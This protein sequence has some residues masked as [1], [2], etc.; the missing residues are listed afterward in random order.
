MSALQGFCVSCRENHWFSSDGPGWRCQ[1]CHHY[2]EHT[3]Q[4]NICK[5]CGHWSANQGH[6]EACMELGSPE[7]IGHDLGGALLNALDREFRAG[8]V[9]PMEDVREYIDRGYAQPL[10][11][12]DDELYR[13]TCTDAFRNELESTLGELPYFISPWISKATA[14]Y[15]AVVKA[16]SPIERSF[17]DAHQRLN[18]PELHGIFPQ[19]HALQYKIDFGRADWKIGIELDGFATHSSTTAIANDRQ[20]QRALEAEGWRIIR[21]GGQEIHRDADACVR[22]AAELVRKLLPWTD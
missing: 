16:M 7:R 1:K 22:Q 11:A 15:Q 17:W 13:L 21:F 3:Y 20:R 4:K 14:R 6:V 9:L 8:L 2:Q 19:V 18:L 12:S 10:P 5:Q